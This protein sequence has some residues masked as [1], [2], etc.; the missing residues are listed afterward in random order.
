MGWVGKKHFYIFE[1]TQ[2]ISGEVVVPIF[3]Y[4]YQGKLHAKC[5][6]PEFRENSDHSLWIIIPSNIFFSDESLLVVDIE[7]FDAMYN[8]IQM[9]D[10]SLLYDMCGQEMHG[11]FQI[12]HLMLLCSLLLLTATD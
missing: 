7:D 11:Q 4:K 6:T 1:P 3:F 9:D 2:L 12:V 10:G 5:V 8:E